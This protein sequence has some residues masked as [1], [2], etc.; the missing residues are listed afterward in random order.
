M[1]KTIAFVIL[2]A[3]ALALAENPWPYAEDAAHASGDRGNMCLAVRNDA[4]TAL[5]AT[6]GDYIPLTTDVDGKLWVTSAGA[7]SG[8][9]V[10]DAAET[11]GGGLSMAGAVVR[12]GKT[13]STAT[14]GDNATVNV[15][16]EGGLWLASDQVEDAAETA[17]A[18]LNMCGAVRRDTAASSSTTTGDNSTINTDATGH[19][20]VM[21]NIL[22]VAGTT[23]VVED[24]AETAAGNLVPIGVVVRAGKTGSTATAGDNA[25]V[26]VDA[27]G[28]MWGAA[29]QVEDTAEADAMPLSMAGAVV[30]A[31]VVGSSATGG[32]NATLN[33]NTVGAL[34]VIET[35]ALTAVS[36]KITVAAA[37]TSVQGG[38]NVVKQC[39]FNGPATNTGQC[40]LAAS[41]GDHRADSLA[42]LETETIGPIQI[43]NTNLVWADCITSGDYIGFFCTN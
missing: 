17:A 34:H 9:Y 26:N 41:T 24:A 13:G 36:G 14:A 27:T 32:D 43:S 3:P 25:T 35:G 5:A 2:L 30:R 31:T 18:P 22:T 42:V 37:G 20:W 10:E 6:T 12:A 7:S 15:T 28:G 29:D 4:G 38:S 23:A 40:F 11:A 19:L 8:T 1:H 16:T 21:P 33:V 39:W